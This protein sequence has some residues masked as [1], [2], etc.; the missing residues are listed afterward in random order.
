[1]SNGEVYG[2]C[3]WCGDLHRL[4]LNPN[5]GP[6]SEVCEDDPIYN[7]AENF[8][9]VEHDYLGEPGERCEGSGTVPESLD[10][11]PTFLMS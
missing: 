2:W 10:T 8:L 11:D 4:I 9:L 7:E 6:A 1:M 3:D 5:P